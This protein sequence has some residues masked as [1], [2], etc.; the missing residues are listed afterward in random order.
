MQLSPFEMKSLLGQVL[1]AHEQAN[2]ISEPI[3]PALQSHPWRSIHVN[4]TKTALRLSEMGANLATE[5]VVSVQSGGFSSGSFSRIEVLR[6]GQSQPLRGMFGR[7]LNVAI[8]DPFDG[9]VLE[10]IGFDTHAS[11]EESNE[12]ARLIEWLDP[13]TI[14]V[15]SV[16]DDGAEQLSDAARAAC[17]SLG[18]ARIR[19]L[20]YR[21]SWCLIGEKG[22]ERGSVPE[23]YRRA[24]AGPTETI[25]K[26]FDLG[27]KRRMV[28][29][30]TTAQGAAF[31]GGG[32]QKAAATLLL[33][34]QGRWL[35]RRMN[36][37]A[38]NRVPQDFYPKVWK[39][40][41]Q[42]KGIMIGKEFMPRDPTV[43]EKTPEEFNF[44]ELLVH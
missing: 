1:G 28:L 8:I 39:I 13:G 2:S 26:T 40:L 16:Q 4:S 5:L 22:S 18:S 24:D 43:S 20:R 27:Q 31:I 33:P 41:S 44:G 17:E 9:S 35:R 38:L 15:V 19:E 29:A 37:G 30:S 36:D 23:S 34:S 6:D 12:F 10:R 21:D 7:G 25:E 11:Q 3:A 42:T 32:G 14:V